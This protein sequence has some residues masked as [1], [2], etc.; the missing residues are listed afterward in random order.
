[1]DGSLFVVLARKVTCMA[2]E[3]EDGHRIG[4]M[5]ED[6]HAG[7]A[8]VSVSAC[9]GAVVRGAV[10]KVAISVRMSARRC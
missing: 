5:T 6:G 7:L 8:G 2:S 1:M 3:T 9:D 10:H 4:A